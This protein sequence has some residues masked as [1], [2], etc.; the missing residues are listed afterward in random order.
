MGD[1]CVRSSLWIADLKG[2]SIVGPAETCLPEEL[3][4]LSWADSIGPYFLGAL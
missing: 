2:T 3:L 1:L 4:A